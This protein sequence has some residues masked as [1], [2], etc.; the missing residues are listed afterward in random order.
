MNR[1]PYLNAAYACSYI[2]AVVL[3]MNYGPESMPFVDGIAACIAFLSLFVLS[4]A[5]MGYFFAFQPLALLVERKQKES[6]RFF[7]KTAAAF[8]GISTIVLSVAFAFAA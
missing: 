8:V 1:S 3:L 7:L 2:C 5:M 6:A 4:A